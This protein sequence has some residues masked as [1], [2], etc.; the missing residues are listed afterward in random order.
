MNN[1]IKLGD[2]C[3]QVESMKLIKKFQNAYPE[4]RNWMKAIDK[5][6][7]KYRDYIEREET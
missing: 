6:I 5:N 2:T 3:K 4:M 7:R 1:V